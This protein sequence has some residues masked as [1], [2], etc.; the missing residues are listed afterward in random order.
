MAICV[1]ENIYSEILDSVK[2]IYGTNSVDHVKVL[3]EYADFYDFRED[4]VK[5]NDCY[6]AIRDIYHNLKMDEEERDAQHWIDTYLRRRI[7]N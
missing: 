1:I 5:E 3:E 7:K 4:F 6:V 2:Y